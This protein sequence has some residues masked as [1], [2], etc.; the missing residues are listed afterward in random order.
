LLFA[1]RV[2]QSFLAE[3]GIASKNKE[4]LRRKDSGSGVEEIL[5]NWNFNTK[6]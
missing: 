1:C 5:I 4:V 2:P 3:R 6:P